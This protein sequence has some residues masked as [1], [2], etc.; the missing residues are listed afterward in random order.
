MLDTVGR[1]AFFFIQ[2]GLSIPA[3][4]DSYGAE[5]QCE[6]ALRAARWPHGLHCPARGGDS[7]CCLGR[8]AVFQC[9]CS[10]RQACLLADTIF[11]SAKLPLAVWVSAMYL[12]SR[13]ENGISALELGCRPASALTPPSRS[14]TS[15]CR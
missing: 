1:S 13:A 3:F 7:F 12:L 8:R 2:Q 6:D 11:E 14:S 5:R 15:R 10:K 4:R 9:N